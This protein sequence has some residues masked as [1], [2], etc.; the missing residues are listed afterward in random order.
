MPITTEQRLVNDRWLLN[1]T[2]ISKS[3]IWADK[4]HTY[5]IKDDKFHPPDK[6]AYRDLIA[7]TSISF[8]K[9]HIVWS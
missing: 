8:A 6:Q 9:E 3:W 7:I 2:R 5:I 4:G 1:L